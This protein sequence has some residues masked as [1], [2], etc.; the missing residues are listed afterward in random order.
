MAKHRP[1]AHGLIDPRKLQVFTSWA[2]PVMPPTSGSVVA[3]FEFTRI[4]TTPTILP[5]KFEEQLIVG[6]LFRFP[7]VER[8]RR[9][10]LTREHSMAP[11]TV[12]PRGSRL[13]LARQG[14]ARFPHSR[15][16]TSRSA[17]TVHPTNTLRNL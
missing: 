12:V 6:V 5:K 11:L 13:P 15:S 14:L 8:V 3:Q 16:S 2:L 9:M 1:T 17:R 10:S 4:N 7:S